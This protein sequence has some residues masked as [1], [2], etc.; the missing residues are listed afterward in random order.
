[1]V[2]GERDDDA[3]LILDLLSMTCKVNAYR[4]PGTE[5]MINFILARHL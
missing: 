4:F 5:M 2:C 1:V 3:F